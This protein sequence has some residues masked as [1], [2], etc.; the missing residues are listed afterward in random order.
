MKGPKIPIFAI[1]GHPNKGKS[2]IVS[3]LAQDPSV[4]IS[5]LSGTTVHTRIYPMRVDGE[6]LYKLIDTP[7]FQRARAAMDWM[8]KHST[9]AS[10]HAETVK[11]FVEKH[12]D[13]KQFSAECE[14]L[15]PIL[16]GAGILY[17]ID[18]SVPYG[19]EYDAEMEILRWTGQPSMALIN[20][21]GDSEYF[22]QWQQPLSQYFRIVRVFNA[23]TASFDRQIQLLTGFSELSDTWHQSLQK[24]AK[25]LTAQRQQRIGESARCIA[26][27]IV[28]MLGASETSPLKNKNS[29]TE[30]DK[31]KT[32]FKQKLIHMEQQARNEV[33]SIFN[34]KGL[35]RDEAALGIEPEDLFSERT[36]KLFGL[37]RDQLVTT[38]MIGGAA[39]GSLL[40]IGSGGLTLF[41]GSGIG[42][43]VGGAS[44]WFGSK[45]L[46]GARV[47]GLP[48]GGNQIVI[49]P[50]TNLNFPWIILGRAVSH[51]RLICQ[52]THAQ[53]DL[54]EV[55]HRTGSNI[56]AD[57]PHAQR[58]AIQQIFT[59]ATKSQEIKES[60]LARLAVVITGLTADSTQ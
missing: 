59:R 7:G 15:T 25:L 31:A 19:P 28:L 58:R 33:E 30:I 23:K 14:L 3:T 27:S 5:P 51:L 4:Q 39:G 54:L 13:Q 60:E 41:L 40:D 44:A 49:G 57:I 8:Q 48:M 45:Q 46:I 42:A 56:V 32:S 35:E 11:K 52:R 55:E 12:R 43:I 6:E 10:D 26:E 24:A 37:S 22:E 21:I 50:I 38:G 36:W 1:V 34:Y 29:Q 47:L 53:R 18:G 17:V 20:Q 16:E 9:S 2:S